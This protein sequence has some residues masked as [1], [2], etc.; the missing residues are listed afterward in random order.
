MSE[1][2]IN[3]S[4]L[5]LRGTTGFPA[6]N[7]PGPFRE[8]GRQLVTTMMPGRNPHTGLHPS[9]QQVHLEH[10]CCLVSTS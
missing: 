4:L 6:K 5:P 2:E 3:S 10:V 8:P 1:H 7:T 9:S